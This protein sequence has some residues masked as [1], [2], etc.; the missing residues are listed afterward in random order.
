MEKYKGM[1]VYC[2][3]DEEIIQM[4][5]TEEPKFIFFVEEPEVLSKF[6]TK[7]DDTISKLISGY[8]NTVIKKENVYIVKTKKAIMEEI[9]MEE[10]D[11]PPVGIFCPKPGEFYLITF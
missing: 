11:R 2:I 9:I 7:V 6:F 1:R 8:Y 3:N 5:Q 4:L 10:I